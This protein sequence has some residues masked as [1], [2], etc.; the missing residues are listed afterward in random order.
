MGRSKQTKKSRSNPEKKTVKNE[1]SYDEIIPAWMFDK[2]DRNGKFAFD[3]E[4]PD[5]NHHE[6]LDKMISYGTMTWAQLEK[7]THDGKSKHH[8]LDADKLS[9][10]A[11]DRLTAMCLEESSDQIYSIALQNRLRVVGLR[12]RDKFHV[13]WYDPEHGVCTSTKKHT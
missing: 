8:Y 4:R 6:F 1:V 2:I 5:F 11:Q 13:L 12:D 10:E 7:Q 9:K 3:I